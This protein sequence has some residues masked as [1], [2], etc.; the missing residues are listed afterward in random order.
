[1]GLMECHYSKEEEDFERDPCLEGIYK[2]PTLVNPN[3]E[4]FTVLA[5]II[6]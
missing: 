5:K 3:F 2:Q 6:P 4:T 1:M